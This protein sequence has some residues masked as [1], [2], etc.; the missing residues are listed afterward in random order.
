MLSSERDRV[1]QTLCM[2]GYER[3]EAL[4]R[5]LRDSGYFVVTAATADVA[6]A[7]L[8]ARR[9]PTAPP[10]GQADDG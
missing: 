7:L 6:M 4:G 1:M 2:V 8:A 10:R 9:A 3:D 5:L